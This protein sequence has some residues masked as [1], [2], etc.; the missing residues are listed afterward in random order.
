MNKKESV[1]KNVIYACIFIGLFGMLIRFFLNRNFILSSDMD[2]HYHFA[3]QLPL[4]LKIGITDF[5]TRVQYPHLI[6][7]P[8]WHI[9]FDIIYF[10]ILKCAELFRWH[11]E[12]ETIE[13]YSQAIENTIL[14]LV[15]FAIIIKCY[16]Q[17]YKINEYIS[18]I[19][20]FCLLFV[21]PLYVPQINSRY[22][23]GQ[24]TANPWHNPTIFMVKPFAVFCFFIFCYLYNHRGK[25]HKGKENILF[26]VFSI[27]LLFSAWM[28]PSFYQAFL[29][30]LCLFCIIDVVNTKFKEILF[31]LKTAIAVLPVCTLAIMQYATSFGES[32]I[33][34]IFAPW[35]VWNM[36]TP[37]KGGS[38]LLS[39]AFPIFVLFA[40]KFRILRTVD[41]LLS[42]LF[43]FSAVI[44]FI[45][46]SFTGNAGTGDFLW[47][48]Y[49]SVLIVFMVC[50][51]YFLKMKGIKFRI[52]GMILLMHFIC[53]LI[54]WIK[55]YDM[56]TF[57]L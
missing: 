48:V 1:S 11:I 37:N 5:K 20:G 32:D 53:G 18:I 7:Y 51:N 17:Y 49:L 27:S 24:F 46:F 15:T 39:M 43:F 41:G 35:E 47:G 45:L 44:Q 2:E 25:M 57:N 6:S 10:I 8:G 3:L 33:S 9:F 26:A 31:C 54:Y 55:V 56:G 21:G 40:C 4:V 36:Y 30:A 16:I 22:Y 29:P 50:G 38:I 13:I 34:I 14:I 12:R 52:S 42:Q 28:K 23:L 19:C